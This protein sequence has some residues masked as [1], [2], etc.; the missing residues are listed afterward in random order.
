MVVKRYRK[1]DDAARLQRLGAKSRLADALGGPLW[2][3]VIAAL[4]PR[5]YPV[6]LRRVHPQLYT[7]TNRITLP[8]DA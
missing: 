4:L 7:S 8:A 2:R 6:I 3:A 1:I 5:T